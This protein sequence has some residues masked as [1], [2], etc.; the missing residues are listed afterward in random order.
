M[1][2]K[3]YDAVGNLRREVKF[4]DGEPNIESNS[5]G[6]LIT[7]YRYDSSYRVSKVKTPEGKIIHY[8]YDGYGRQSQ[9][10]T[11]DAGLTSYFYDKNDNLIFSQD[12]NQKAVDQ[13][14]Y[15][16]RNYDGLNRLTGIGEKIFEIDAPSDGSQYNSSTDAYYLTINVYDTI[17]NSIVSNLFFTPSGYTSPLY[18]KGNLAATAYRTKTS[19]NWNYKYYKYDVRGRV[20]KM[21]N[22][23]ADFDTL[24]TEYI[25]NSQ[26][27]ITFLYYQSGKADSKS[28]YYEYDYTGRLKNTSYYTGPPSDNPIDYTNLASY[29]YNANSQVS[30][31]NFNGNTLE[32]TYS[33]NSRNWITLME[34]SNN[35][36]NYEN[37]YFK[38]G[39]VKTQTLSGN[40][41]DSFANNANLNFSYTYD[42]SNRLLQSEKGSSYKLINTYDKD[43]NILT[44]KRYGAT[45]NRIDSFN[46]VYNSGANRL[47][48]V[49]GSISQY[50][51]DANGNMISDNLNK[52]NYVRYDYRNLIIE[53]LHHSYTTHDTLLITRYNYDEAGNRVRKLIYKHITHPFD[54]E[55]ENPE[56]ELDV[57][58]TQYW[59]FVKEEIYSRDVSGREMAIYVNGGIDE[60]PIYGLDMI[61]KL[62]NDVPNYYYKDHLGSVRAVVNS[63]N[64]LVSAQDYDQWGYLL[65][66]RTY[67]SNE[68]KF[69]FTEK[70]RDAE[71]NYDYFGA[72]YY[73]ARI[74]RWGSVDPLQGKEPSKTPYH[75]TS[76]N[77]INKIDPTGLDDIYFKDG[78]EVDRKV[79]E[80]FFGKIGNWLFGDTYYVQSK[81]GNE[82]YNGNNYFEALSEATVKQFANWDRVFSDWQTSSL[83]EGF[84]TRLNDAT[85]DAPANLVDKYFYVLKEANG[86]KLDQ[87]LNL[88]QNTLYVYNNI[89]LNYQE[90]GNTLFGA[91]IYNLGIDLNIANV[92]G[93]LFSW[94]NNFR[95]DEF[96]EVQAYKIGYYNFN[97]NS[98]FFRNRAVNKFR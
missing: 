29:D 24:T 16:F 35:I 75:Y 21:W 72:R 42:K 33:Y 59:T 83:E 41:N 36:F 9:R 62:K 28:Y 52:N 47:N 56:E 57:S 2:E 60:Y 43:G 96:N 65:Q 55:P 3:Y 81:S 51:Y 77:P 68:S 90:A 86:G 7:D 94:K 71:S 17:A 63:S 34:S 84:G 20:I 73:D 25:Y 97:S 48:R 91:A 46:Y 15:T 70:E 26:D 92:G 40:Y 14:K 13:F 39:N 53:L 6:S 66:S 1:F 95:P 88:F 74:G 45:A 85:K 50:T 32:N 64:Q 10:I 31:Q 76:D 38:N 12:A 67:A 27:Q 78:V 11:P 37:G 30:N 44:L 23:I 49:T 89:A 79:S 87:K 4:I 19:D 93:E 69:K 8:Y 82:S 61:G 58:D 80:G 22:I 18:T 5:T 54:P 98:S